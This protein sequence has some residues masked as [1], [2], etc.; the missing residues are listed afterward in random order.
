MKRY[1]VVPGFN[2]LDDLLTGGHEDEFYGQTVDAATAVEAVC[3]IDSQ[4]RGEVV[5]VFTEQQI[6]DARFVIKKIQ[7]I[8]LV[9]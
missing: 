3:E 6:R 8:E 2:V 7:S 5:Y 1:F 9:K 4:D